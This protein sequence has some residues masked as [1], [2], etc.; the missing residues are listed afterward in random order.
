LVDWGR[1]GGGCTQ[2]AHT[3]MAHGPSGQ[4]AAEWG[5]AGATGGAVLC[6]DT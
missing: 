5:V 2:K 6:Y 1:E 3:A 4:G